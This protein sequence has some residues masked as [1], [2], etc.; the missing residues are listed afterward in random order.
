MHSIDDSG[1]LVVNYM[2]NAMFRVN[3]DAVV[4]VC[5]WIFL[6]GIFIVRYGI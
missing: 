3:P 4:K 5:P 1:D 6:C 2:S